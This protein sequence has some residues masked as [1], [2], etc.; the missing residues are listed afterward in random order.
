M[1]SNLGHAGKEPFTLLDILLLQM[2]NKACLF[3][4]YL[5]SN[6][7]A[8]IGGKTHTLLFNSNTL[9]YV[10]TCTHNEKEG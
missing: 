3:V 9:N 2:S 1:G 4:K 7:S 8:V 5:M 6:K 10:S